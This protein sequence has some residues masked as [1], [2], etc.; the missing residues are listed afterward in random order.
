MTATTTVPPTN[1]SNDVSDVRAP[2]AVD[3][4]G[5]VGSMD[6]DPFG[7]AESRDENSMVKVT[8]TE[9]LDPA[10]ID[11]T[12]FSP[13]AGS[14]WFAVSVTMDATGSGIANTGEW[15]L[16]TTDGSQYTTI[17]VLGSTPY[18]AY[19]SFEPGESVEGVVVFEI[20]ENAEVGWIFLSPTIF[21]RNN[22]AFV[23]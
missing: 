23:N 13:E 10:E 3:S 2:L 8:I 20:P 1:A 4:S 12:I 9:V 22:L 6:P 15:T 7:N 21:A 17:I 18:I 14:R 5:K 11:G 19:G 16:A